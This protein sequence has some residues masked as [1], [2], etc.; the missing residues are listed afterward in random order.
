MENKSD[1][2]KIS[3][4]KM[5]DEERLQLASKL[6]RE[7]DEFINALPKKKYEDGWPEDRWEEEMEKHPFFMT[8]V[9][10]PGAEL[11]PLYEGLQKLKYDPEENEPEEL[12]ISYKEDGNFNFKYKNYRLAI[13]SYTEGIKAKCG[14]ADIEATLY[15]NRSAA[16]YFL[17]NYRSSLKDCEQALKIKPDHEK[18]LLRAAQCCFESKKFDLALKYCDRLLDIQKTHK[19]A[20]DLRRKCVQSYKL[21]QRNERKRDLEEKKIKMEEEIFFQEIVSRGI[22]IEGGESGLSL[23]RLEPCFPQLFGHRVHMDEKKHLIWPVVFLYPEYKM[24][25]YIQEFNETHTFEEQLQQVFET[26]PEWDVKSLYTP[27]T[28]NI[29][30]ETPNKKLRTIKLS[31]TLGMVL[32]LK[33]YVV[34][35]G[36]PSF[37]L[38][39][40][41]SDAE[42][43]FLENY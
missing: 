29:Y 16:H 25:D 21:M 3:N 20:L 39:V 31:D 7:L 28:L 36:T 11:H 38:L 23:D 14:I 27:Y 35:G 32:A 5:T 22:N 18:S 34:R 15:N 6:D 43:R 4:R 1:V 42:N 30:F 19:S 17:G 12:A 41:N 40:R 33:E 13:L 2:S 26:S 24:M 8:K 9:P 10:E 37:I